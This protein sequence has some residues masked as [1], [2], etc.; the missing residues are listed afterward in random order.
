MAAAARS[1]ALF[2]TAVPR[3]IPTG[4]YMVSSQVPQNPGGYKRHS[5]SN[6]EFLVGGWFL[7][8]LPSEIFVGSTELEPPGLVWG[9]G[10][11]VIEG[12]L[13]NFGAKNSP[14]DH[15][16]GRFSTDLCF[17]LPWAFLCNHDSLHDW[18]YLV[19]VPGRFYSSELSSCSFGWTKGLGLGGM[20][21]KI[22]Q[23]S[24]DRLDDTWCTH[25]AIKDTNQQTC[26]LI[27]Q[28]YRL[29]SL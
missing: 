12:T 9:D 28:I 24:G 2:Q 4:A 19:L 8:G 1:H 29:P 21:T 3:I 20:K 23:D 14:A 16:I 6:I 11:L 25:S 18:G 17:F 15:S 10:S 13:P 26:V 22:T 5:S 7:C 27:F